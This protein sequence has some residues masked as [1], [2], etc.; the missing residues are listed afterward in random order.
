MK[1][2]KEIK[3]ALTAICTVVILFYGINFL[4]GV[5]LFKKSDLYY[6]IFNDITGLAK[7][8]AVFAN[9]FPI[10][11]VREIN[12]DY[13]HP[14]LVYVGIEV[15]EKMRIPEGSHAELVSS[16]LGSTTMNLRLG[17]TNNYLSPGDSIKGGPQLGALDQVADMMPQIQALLPKL[18]SILHAVNNLVNN[19][20]LT[21][22]LENTQQITAS[23]KETTT[24]MNHLLANDLPKLTAKLDKV[25]NNVDVLTNKLSVLD[26]EKTLNEAQQTLAETRKF[27]QEL[28]E[29]INSTD[30]NLGLMLNDRTLYDNLTRTLASSDS[31]LVNLRQQPKRYVHFSLFGKKDKEKK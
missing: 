5:N 3:I 22:T 2:N 9:G 7:N 21:H 16:M 12:Y 1:F 24:H 25:G 29:K 20:A 6:V 14:G 28:N 8:N 23:L 26:Y 31:L 11:T 13:D 4:K 19:T 27:A 18:D 10:G 15:N 30:G 17:K